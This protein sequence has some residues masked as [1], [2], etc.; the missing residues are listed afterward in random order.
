MNITTRF[1]VKELK[2]GLLL[3]PVNSWDDEYFSEYGYESKEEALKEIDRLIRRV[4]RLT[5][6][7][8]FGF[9]SQFGS[10]YRGKKLTETLYPTPTKQIDIKQIDP[11]LTT[12]ENALPPNLLQQGKLN[13]FTG[14]YLKDQYK[15][16]KDFQ[17]L[18]NNKYYIMDK[19]GDNVKIYRIN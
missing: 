15:N 5:E 16:N 13:A 8:R 1:L 3:D 14:K 6:K 10:S 18:D 12:G 2:N 11:R 4:D 17:K 7:T 9:D 19:Q